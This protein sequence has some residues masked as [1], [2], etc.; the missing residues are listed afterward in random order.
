MLCAYPIFP[1]LATCP[2]YLIFFDLVK[3]TNYEAPHNII[4]L[5]IL[6]LPLSQV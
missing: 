2:T 5:I 3:G 6:L 1:M 4:F